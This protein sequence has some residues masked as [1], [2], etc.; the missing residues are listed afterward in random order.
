MS[1]GFYISSLAEELSLPM[2]FYKGTKDA[3]V[4]MRGTV[5][6]KDYLKEEL[7]NPEFKKAF[8]E[9]EIYASLAIQI[10]KIRQKKKLT[11]A[12]LAKRLHT[13][14]QTVSRLEDIHNQSYSLRTLVELARALNKHLE[15]EFV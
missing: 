4:I 11:Q 9:E 1:I 10:A 2:V 12:E 3:D 8:E 13:T 14:Q 7:K 15:V 5:K 6:F